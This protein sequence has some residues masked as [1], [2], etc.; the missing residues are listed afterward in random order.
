ME[1]VFQ[2][3]RKKKVITLLGTLI[4]A[5]FALTACGQ[6]TPKISE[7]QSTSEKAISET[8]G[9]KEKVIPK[10]QNS[11]E[12]AVSETQS[13]NEKGIPESQNSSE[14]SKQTNEMPVKEQ[15]FN[16]FLIDQKCGVPGID[17][18]GVDISKYPEKHSKECLIN[19]SCVASGY[20]ISIKQENGLYKFYKFDKNGSKRAKEEIV[21]Q[22]NKNDNFMI[23]VKGSLSGDV[24][25][26]SS[27]SEK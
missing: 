14:K 2:M 1:M 11:S 3:M 7:T 8:Q 9:N 27:I 23:M 25:S 24:I 26:L 22:T 21:N 19:P 10:T 12:K 6:S 17:L 20:G 4:L 18:M 16:G 15:V 13:S 5:T